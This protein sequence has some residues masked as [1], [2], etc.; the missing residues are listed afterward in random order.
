MAEL[1]DK[2]ALFLLALATKAKASIV[3]AAGAVAFTITTAIIVLVGSVLISLVPVIAVKLVGGAIMLGYAF[4]EYYRSSNEEHMIEEKEQR[5]LDRRGRGDWSIFFPAL[6]SLMA[7]DLAGD[8]TELLTVVLLAHFR[9]ILLVSSGAVVGLVA[10]AAVE[11]ALGNRLGKVLSP[12]R[13]RYLSVIVFILI[14]TTVIVT[15]LL[16]A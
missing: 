9:D 14:G 13:I 16:G 3:F 6:L 4:W 2:D 7:L 11:T 5:L 8:A 1:T 10:A 12:R 15:T